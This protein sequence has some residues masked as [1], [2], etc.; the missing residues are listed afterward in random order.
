MPTDMIKTRRPI[1]LFQNLKLNDLV[2][3]ILYHM[4]HSRTERFIIG[5]KNERGE[6][7]T[8][9]LVIKLVLFIKS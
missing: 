2:M 5:L 6:V 8:S 9:P 4:V 1:R 3:S 7:D